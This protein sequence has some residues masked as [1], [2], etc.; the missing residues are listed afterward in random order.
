MQRDNVTALLQDWTDGDN[1]ALEKLTPFI[2]AEL[3]RIAGRYM[4][5]ERVGHTLQASALVNEAFLKL[6]DNRRIQWQNRA[7]FYAMSARLMRQILV[8]FARSKKKQKRGGGGMRV[9]LDENLNVIA[10]RTRDLV[11]L[12]DALNALAGTSPRVSQ[13]VELRFFGGLTEE[14]IAAALQISTDTVL[15]DWKFA[16]VWLHR[17]LTR[18]PSER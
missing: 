16:K 10:D 11:A 4:A 9:T 3:R 5:G 15:R 18:G 6:V 2:H 13:V 7:H 12:D 17:E 14:E 8:D 1:G